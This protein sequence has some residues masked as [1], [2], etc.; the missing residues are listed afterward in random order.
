MKRRWPF[1]AVLSLIAIQARAADCTGWAGVAPPVR[2]ASSANRVVLVRDLDGDGVPEIMASG[3]HIDELGAFSLLPNRGDGTFAGE[4][5]IASGFGETLQ[6]IGDLNHD[7]VPDLLVS[8]YWANGIVIYRGNGSLQ[9]DGGTPYGTAT[10]GG[11]SLITD[12]D[13]DGT[14]DVISFS[15]GSGNPVRLHLFHGLGDTTLAPKTTF[16]TGLANADWPSIRTI[17]GVL[18]ILAS[19][20]SGNLALVRYVNGVVSVSRIAAGPAF[21]LS[22]VFADVNGDG[23]ADIVDTG[24]EESA[25]EP[26]FVTLGN[27]DGTFGERR[28]LA[29][30]RKVTFPVVRI[31][32]IDGDGHPDLIVSSLQ[33]TSLYLYR[34]NGAGDFEEGITINAGASIN[35]FDIG[36]V[37]GDG[38]L[39]LVTANSD[40]TVSVIVNRGPCHPSRRRAATH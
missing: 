23:I 21:D 11:P 28:Q 13:G 33:A 26:I 1:V 9:F 20:R 29:H 19:E 7:H 14:P 10:H 2:Y 15:F 22:S 32:D 17:H 30:P 36:D 3:N 31:R 5:L 4:R 25:N 27:A 24:T 39:D 8:N 6:D 38:Y 18:E 12:Y 37:N 40:H 34:G 35:A 16:E